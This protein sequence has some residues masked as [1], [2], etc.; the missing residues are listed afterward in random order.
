LLFLD[1]PLPPNSTGEYRFD[2]QDNIRDFMSPLREGK[3]ELVF[4]PRQ[5]R[6][7]VDK[8]DLVLWVPESFSNVKLTAKSGV[9]GK[10]MN[11]A[12]LANL[13]LQAMMCLQTANLV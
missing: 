3:D 13:V 7:T 9:F 5:A 12:E 2:I 10:L 6:G 1:P 11:P 4:I 8:T